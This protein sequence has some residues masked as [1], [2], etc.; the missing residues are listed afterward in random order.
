M[1]AERAQRRS[2]RCVGREGAAA[3]VREM[4]AEM[5]FQEP[6]T[7]FEIPITGPR[8]SRFFQIH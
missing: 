8:L 4:Q 2:V 6:T 5:T 7:S 3:G 1:W